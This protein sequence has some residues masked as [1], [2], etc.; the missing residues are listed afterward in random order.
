MNN[1][2]TDL[3]KKRILKR[4]STQKEFDEAYKYYRK[5]INKHFRSCFQYLANWEE[6]R[7]IYRKYLDEACFVGVFQRAWCD[8]QVERFDKN[9]VKSFAA[10]DSV[11][12][13]P[14]RQKEKLI[15]A[16][17]K[18]LLTKKEKSRG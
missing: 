2:I 1:Q 6:F 5:K 16:M 7:N 18:K 9:L 4:V 11:R 13:L 14:Q 8:E 12:N 10:A 15:N 17:K 3:K